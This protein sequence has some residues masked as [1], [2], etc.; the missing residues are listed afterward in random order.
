MY[1]YE[2]V[3]TSGT[4]C[5]VLVRTKDTEDELHFSSFYTVTRCWMD[6]ESAQK[7]IVLDIMIHVL[8][9]DP[10]QP[11]MQSAAW[12]CHIAYWSQFKEVFKADNWIVRKNQILL[13]LYD[14]LE[15]QHNSTQKI[16][17]YAGLPYNA[18]VKMFHSLYTGLAIKAPMP[19]RT[20]FE[21]YLAGISPERV[22]IGLL[23]KERNDS[24]RPV[25]EA[26]PAGLALSSVQ[27]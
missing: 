20:I 19:R 26:D 1:E 11:P 23:V 13:W 6:D 8:E 22:I 15:E 10:K 25:T 3:K 9:E 2:G 4:H 21:K 12:L 5:A 16:A 7:Q 24:E 27:G 18:W 17:G 14:W